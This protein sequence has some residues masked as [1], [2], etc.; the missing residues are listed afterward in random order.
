MLGLSVVPT[1]FEAVPDR[2]DIRDWF[3]QPRLAPLPD[4]IVNC[5][6]VPLILDREASGPVTYPIQDFY[7]TNAISRASPTRW[8]PRRLRST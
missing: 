3:Y 4:K 7:L 2:I 8:A 6:R 5:E 1:I